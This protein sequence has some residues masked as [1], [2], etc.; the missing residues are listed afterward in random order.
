MPPAF[1]TRGLSAAAGDD[2]GL[3]APVTGARRG[4]L[5]MVEVAIELRHTFMF[6]L[7]SGKAVMRSRVSSTAI[8]RPSR[9]TGISAPEMIGMVTWP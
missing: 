8:D 1:N 3:P 2:A 7:N 9:V 4:G 5:A 6:S